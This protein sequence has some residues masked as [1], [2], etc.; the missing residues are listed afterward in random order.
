MQRL[1]SIYIHVANHMF[2]CSPCRLLLLGVILLGV[3]VIQI[4]AG[5]C[6]SYDHYHQFTCPNGYGVYRVRGEH[7]NKKEDR[8]Y[9][10]YCE[11]QGGSHSDCYSTGYVNSWDSQVNF[12][13]R[14]NYF[15]AGVRSYHDNGKE[16]RRFDFTCC[17]VNNKC[18]TH[19]YNSFQ[20]NDFDRDMDFNVRGRVLTGAHSR[21]DNKKE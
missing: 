19:C 2:M 16:D 12:R 10:W 3:C 17:R 18:T 4:S 20:V 7:N 9:C 5:Y 21:H 15:I 13:C 14:Q 8:I 6:N 1:F 11:L